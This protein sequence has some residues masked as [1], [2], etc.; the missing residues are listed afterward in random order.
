MP[1]PPALSLPF[2]AFILAIIT[3]S[4]FGVQNAQ[5]APLGL[6]NPTKLTDSA[7]G[8]CD[9]ADCSL[10]EAITASNT[11][12]VDSTV[13][14]LA[15]ATYM[16]TM[17]GQFDDANNSGDLDILADVTINGNDATVQQTAS[18]RVFELYPVVFG[19]VT[20][21]NLTITGGNE[22]NLNEGGGGI[23]Q[24]AGSLTL[25]NVTVTDND[26]IFHG[27]G[28]FQGGDAAL[29]INNST[30]SLNRSSGGNGGGLYKEDGVGNVEISGS[31]FSGNEAIEGGGMFLGKSPTNHLSDTDVTG[32][33]AHFPS[34]NCAAGGGGIFV[35]ASSGETSVTIEGGSVSDNHSEA[36]AGG[37]YSHTAQISGTVFDGNSAN[38]YGGAIHSSG[39]IVD[40]TISNNTAKWG[41]GLV[42]ISSV[43]TVVSQTSINN[44]HASS[45][46]GGVLAVTSSLTI[47][48]SAI[49]NNTAS[50]VGGGIGAGQGTTTVTNTTVD[51][52]TAA[53]GGGIAKAADA[54]INSLL[55]DATPQGGPGPGPLNV[56]FS[57]ISDN[58]ATTAGANI[59]FEP[60]NGP[61]TLSASVVAYSHTTSDCNVAI[62]SGGANV[63]EGTS[64]GFNQTNDVTGV[65]PLLGTLS[66]NGGPT[67]TRALI[68]N[69]P[70]INRVS[71]ALCSGTTDDQ[72]G[73]ARP[74]GGACDSGAF[75]SAF[76]S[77]PTLTPTSEPTPSATPVV[78]PKVWGDNDCD[79]DSDGN[80]ATAILRHSLG[81]PDQVGCFPAID[82][83]VNVDGTSRRWGDMNCDGPADPLDAL[84][85]LLQKVQLDAG[86]PVGCPHAG[87]QV[88]VLT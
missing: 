40:A 28:I 27:G 25:N 77:T 80:D 36:A 88:N 71:G 33:T 6:H 44:N 66:N 5:S 55:G 26:A 57:T 13:N 54:A 42:S 35:Y 10:R 73:T 58:T 17:P 83:S 72:R 68:K 63:E 52:N 86:L 23:A 15:D 37:L 47:D 39:N 61:L 32:N 22:V 2:S 16:L 38:D 60:S 49:F 59:F 70:A 75:E 11:D 8:V 76:T 78:T 74:V 34:C 41:A 4:L 69:S 20:I 46:G 51:G 1:R 12:G 79:D 48:H 29:T 81:L 18:D 53:R 62:A 84:A 43:P 56:S 14:L 67:N 9:L 19:G 7:D 82:A 65:D 3:I 30:V 31:T 24:N 85:L 64:C 87:D 21:N 45:D 50:D